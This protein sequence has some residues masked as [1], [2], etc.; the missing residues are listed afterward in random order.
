MNPVLGILTSLQII[1]IGVGAIVGV[2]L[3]S[4]LFGIAVLFLLLFLGIS[5]KHK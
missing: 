4:M 5:L 1:V 3:N 2:P